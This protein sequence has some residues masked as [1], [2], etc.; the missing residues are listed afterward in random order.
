MRRHLEP[1]WEIAFREKRKAS[2]SC[3]QTDTNAEH[4]EGEDRTPPS[5]DLVDRSIA[6]RRFQLVI[7]RQD[8]VPASPLMLFAFGEET[9][10]RPAK[11]VLFAQDSAHHERG[12]TLSSVP[13]HGE[14]IPPKRQPIDLELQWVM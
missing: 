7:Q 13:W 4:D 9:L 5:W 14:R 1:G 2:D 11:R 3:P 12:R 10:C 8:I 6:A